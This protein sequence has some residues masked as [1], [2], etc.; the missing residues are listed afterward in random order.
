MCCDSWGR[1]ESDRDKTGDSGRLPLPGPGLRLGPLPPG[2]PPHPLP[3]FQPS[4]SGEELWAEPRRLGFEFKGEANPSLSLSEPQSFLQLRI[5]S[6]PA[7]SW[8]VNTTL[9]QMGLVP[10]LLEPPV[11]MASDSFKGL[12]LNIKTHP[13]MGYWKNHNFD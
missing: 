13:Y 11:T 9:S 3:L 7:L 8:A 2:R 4:E 1:K 12:D 10:A 6:K 5:Y